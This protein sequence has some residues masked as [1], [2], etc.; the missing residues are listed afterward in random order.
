MSAI[1]TGVAGNRRRGPHTPR[2]AAGPFALKAG[3]LPTDAIAALL[4]HGSS[5]EASP[6]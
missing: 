6:S 2:H 3:V 5:S 1:D 4:P